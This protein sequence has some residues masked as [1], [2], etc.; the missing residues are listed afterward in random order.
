[1]KRIGALWPLIIS[2]ANLLDAARKAQQAKR[3]R[4]NVLQFN[5]N[6]EPEILSL[7]RELSAKSYVP[8]KYN[9]FEVFEP[10][11]RCISAAPYRDRV[12]HHALCNIVGPII[13]KSLLAD[14]YANRAGFGTHSALRRFTAFLR[15]SKYV[16]KCDIS[17][18]Y[19][20]VDH[21]I[22]KEAIARKIKCPDTLWLS[23]TFIDGGST[24]T[25][26]FDYFPGDDLF[27]PGERAHGLPIG[28]L[29]SQF[30]ANLYLSPLDH[31]VK[32]ELRI[33]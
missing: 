10:K 12:V 16:L 24:Q 29:T 19:P 26:P 30:F 23:G 7:Q 1:M 15:S 31:F 6:L 4:G 21:S 14:T 25:E 3:F 18:F 28:N 27:T 5:Y 33:A 32:E 8:G 11:R 13:E 20:S 17:K 9:N 22:L 2:F